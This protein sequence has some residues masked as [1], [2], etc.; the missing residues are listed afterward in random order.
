[1]WHS[2]GK[3]YL[4]CKPWLTETYDDLD[5]GL[6]I[7][8]Q[9]QSKFTSVKPL[10]E[11]SA[12][13]GNV[14]NSLAMTRLFVQTNNTYVK[15]VFAYFAFRDE[16][17]LQN[18]NNL[19]ENFNHLEKTIRDFKSVPQFDY[20][21]FGVEQ[22]IR[23]VKK[24]LTDPVKA[25]EEL[26]LAPTS[27]QIEKAVFKLHEQYK[28]ILSVNQ[29]EL[30][31]L[32]HFEA[33]IDGRDILKIH[34]GSYEIEHLRWDPPTIK[35]CLFSVPLPEREVTIIVKVLQAR[36]LE[37]FVLEQPNEKNNYTAQIY[38]YDIPEGRDWVK[39]DLYY[40]DKS[41]KELGLEV[42]WQ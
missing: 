29:T 14:E 9:M 18:K 5:H 34:K 11:D 4:R 13:A 33:Q 1:M 26:A 3:V 22:I 12:L 17:S 19:A 27:D 23:N 28:K 24:S 32:L 35:D 8:N 31:K 16:P 40:I 37:P 10:I 25:Q 21:L 30:K 36:D 2:G 41:P 42:P 7:A 39:F 20:K 38:M 15:T 6:A